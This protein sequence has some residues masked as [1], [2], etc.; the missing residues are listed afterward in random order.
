[1]VSFELSDCNKKN[2][3]FLNRFSKNTQTSDSMKICPVGAELFHAGGRTDVQNERY[4]EA[5]SHFTQF[6]ERNE[7]GTTAASW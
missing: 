3:Y 5:N 7:M 2:L 6:I 4:E 1:M